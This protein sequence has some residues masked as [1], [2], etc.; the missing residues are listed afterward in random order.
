MANIVVR[1]PRLN[2]KLVFN[3]YKEDEK[4]YWCERELFHPVTGKRYGFSRMAVS[5]ITR[6]VI[7]YQLDAGDILE[8]VDGD[9][10][11]TLH[12]KA[13]QKPVKTYR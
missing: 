4:Y 6:Y 7:G 12:I 13:D 9:Y 3:V 1:N 2:K 5:K 11:D 10:V 8:L